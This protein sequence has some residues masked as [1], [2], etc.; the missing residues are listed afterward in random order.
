MQGRLLLYSWLVRV[1]HISGWHMLPS[2]QRQSHK[3]T[4]APWLLGSCPGR[5]ACPAWCVSCQT[6]FGHTQRCRPAAGQTGAQVA[7]R[8]QAAL[9]GVALNSMISRFITCSSQNSHEIRSLYLVA[10]QRR[11]H[12]LAD[13]LKYLPLHS[14][15]QKNFGAQRAK[16]QPSCV[17]YTA[18][19]EAHW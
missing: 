5:P 1:S 17:A 12:Q 11:L 8:C 6:L 7:G 15:Q 9:E 13:L 10:I 14:I 4:P 2:M 19:I 18:S 16:L 3:V